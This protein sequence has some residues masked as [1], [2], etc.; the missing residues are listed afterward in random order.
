MDRSG[1][2]GPVFSFGLS[3]IFL[4]TGGFQLKKR[5]CC[6]KMLLIVETQI[7]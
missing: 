3:V 6:D 2:F 7:Q 4:E 5:R 1:S